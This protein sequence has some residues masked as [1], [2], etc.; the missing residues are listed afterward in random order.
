MR[1]LLRLF[2]LIV[3]LVGAGLGVALPWAN[4]NREGYEIGQWR[5]YERGE[6]YSEALVP[7]APADA[8][9]WA[10][11]E[12]TTEGPLPASL[13][14][15]VLTLTATVSG[16]TVLAE[17]VD[18]DGL[19]PRVTAPQAAE[20][21]Y[22][23]RLPPIDPVESGD[24][25]FTAGPGDAESERI[26][27]ADLHVNAGLFDVDSR[28]PPIGYVMIVIGVVGLVLSFRGAGTP[29]REAAPAPRWGR[30]NDED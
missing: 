13:R 28:L 1:H 2:L 21:V 15:A 4:A 7:V 29:Q 27:A 20:H 18:L 16:R 5:L 10:R 22:L 24:Y 3:A 8:P 23:L 17:A 26:L 11:V 25:R 6:G 14:G 9:L 12:V 30:R 19:Q